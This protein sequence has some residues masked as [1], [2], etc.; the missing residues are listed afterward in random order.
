MKSSKQYDKPSSLT[1]E[2]TFFLWPLITGQQLPETGFLGV[3]LKQHNVALLFY[4]YLK[5]I[6]QRILREVEN[7]LIRSVLV[8]SR[9]ARF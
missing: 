7:R 6:V 2:V 5:G 8:N 3:I 9:P 1:T 4:D